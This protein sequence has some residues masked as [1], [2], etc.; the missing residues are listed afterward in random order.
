MVA[1]RTTKPVV[2]EDY[3]HIVLSVVGEKHPEDGLF[4][5]ALRREAALA[6]DEHVLPLINNTWPEVK[7]QR[8]YRKMRIA[9]EDV[10]AAGPYCA[11]LLSP[12][13]PMAVRLF[14]RAA[15]MLKLSP[16][17]FAGAVQGLVPQLARWTF[18]RTRRRIV[19]VAAHIVVADEVLDGHFS[20]IAPALRGAAFRGLMEGQRQPVSPAQHL[21]A[22]IIAGLRE[23]LNTTERDELER[24]VEQCCLWAE[25]EANNLARIADPN[26]LGWRRDGILGGPMG[27]S[28]AVRDYIGA[29]S[30]EWMLAVSELV[31]MLDDLLDAHTDRTNG[32]T[33]PVHTGQW[34]GDTL[35]D[36]YQRALA[37]IELVAA[38]S[39]MGPQYIDMTVRAFRFQ[40]RDLVDKMIDGVAA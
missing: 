19:L 24:G 21:V 38:E 11:L 17:Q 18:A 7:S 32:L 1:Q 26:G 10:Y 28:W 30:H 2:Q 29:H 13:A 34:N 31:Q 20:D 23:G 35:R 8:F 4:A 12:R 6:F 37:L 27:A 14:M 33:T 22:A 36:S 15:E 39:G 5:H 3:Q 16:R 40:M 25:A 9:V